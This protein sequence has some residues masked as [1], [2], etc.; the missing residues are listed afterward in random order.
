MEGTNDEMDG[1]AEEEVV[2]GMELKVDDDG[3]STVV[4]VDVDGALASISG[5]ADNADADA[6]VDVKV[7]VVVGNCA[8]ELLF[9]ADEFDTHALS[10][11]PL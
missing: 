1:V 11:R 9:D 7:V 5:A 3:A 8:D 4:D 6:D 2:E 10:F